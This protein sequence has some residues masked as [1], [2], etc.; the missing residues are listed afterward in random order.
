MRQKC[1]LNIT[2]ALGAICTQKV[3]ITTVSLTLNKIR[4]EFMI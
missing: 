2:L 3:E 4:T 1:H